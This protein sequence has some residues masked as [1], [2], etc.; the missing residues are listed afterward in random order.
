MKI[1]ILTFTCANNYGAL[2][3]AYALYS[4]LKTKG[5]DVSCINYCPKYLQ[6]KYTPFSYYRIF[7]LGNPFKAVLKELLLYSTL[8]KKNKGFELF[9]NR[10]LFS[11]YGDFND[12]NVII[13]GSDQVWNTKLTH[14]DS[15]FLGNIQYNKATLI[16]YA[17]SAES[18]IDKY[19]TIISDNLFR[20]SKISVREESLKQFLE[21][22]FKIKSELVVDPTLLFNADEWR[23][24]EK[25]Y[26]LNGKFVFAYIFGMSKNQRKRLENFARSLNCKLICLS[27]STVLSRKYVNDA[28]PDQ[29][30]WLIRNAE[31]VVTN[32]F[33]GTVFSIIFNKSFLTL[34]KAKNQRI[35]NLLELC[36]CS[37]LLYEDNLDFK[38]DKFGQV[39]TSKQVRLLK[40]IDMS[41]DFLK[42]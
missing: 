18:T 24:I 9:R 16:S 7:S 38:E 1:G 12:Y 10:I 41:K 2:L 14:N 30:I 39:E 31:Y 17:A 27:V 19:N 23:Q 29:F 15:V 34:K 25:P 22:E 36:G 11:E 28:T 21:T 3:Q 6:E 5:Y 20:F 26:K 37:N 42:L 32:S 40:L 4:Y 33:H 8:K 35:E 13:I